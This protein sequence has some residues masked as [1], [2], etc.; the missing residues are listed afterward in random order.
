[1]A[2]Q[3]MDALVLRDAEGNF[4][5]FDREA[6]ARARVTDSAAKSRLEGQVELASSEVA[7]HAAAQ[8]GTPIK[9]DLSGRPTV[10]GQGGQI[11]GFWPF[12]GGL[13]GG[14]EFPQA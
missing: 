10:G 11:L 5:V 4:Y 7:G 12:P 8:F 13:P 3:T 9:I 14:V 2:E 1:M 6:F